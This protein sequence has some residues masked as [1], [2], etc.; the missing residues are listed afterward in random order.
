MSSNKRKVIAVD[1]DGTLAHYD[2]WRGIHHIG[3]P[4]PKMLARVKQW[5]EEGHGVTIFTARMSPTACL[6]N[7]QNSRA[8][9]EVIEKWCVQHVGVLLPVTSEKRMSFSEFWDDRAIQ[10]IPNTGERADGKE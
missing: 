5:L 9:Q 4:V 7:G 3:D 8:V 2:K 10:I 1:L 6:V